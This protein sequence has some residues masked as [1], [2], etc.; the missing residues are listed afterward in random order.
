MVAV[1]CKNDQPKG[2]EEIK[3]AKL[4]SL[5][6]RISEMEAIGKEQISRDQQS[7]LFKTYQEYYNTSGKD[8]ISL[9]YLF[10]AAN[11][12]Q[13]L[14]KYQKAVDLFINFHDGFPASHRCDEAV[15]NIA[16]IYDEKLKNAEKAT[17][18]YNKVI[19]LYPN[20]LWAEEAKAALHFVGLSDEETIKKL[21]A[22]NSK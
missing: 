6:K 3:K 16:Y 13:V 2:P 11:L 1:G 17:T 21:E 20:S 4:D 8:T 22:I 12:A 5:Q 15:F 14:G 7:A 10:E 18:Y 19:E 9:N